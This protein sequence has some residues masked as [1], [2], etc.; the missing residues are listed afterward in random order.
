ML[1]AN[2]MFN[3]LRIS[4]F[5]SIILLVCTLFDKPNKAKNGPD[6]EVSG[7]VG[8]EVNQEVSQEVSQEKS[9]ETSEPINNLNGGENPYTDSYIYSRYPYVEYVPWRHWRRFDSIR[10]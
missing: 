5:A 4:L 3:L 8:E 10:Y 1:N 7:E 2:K 6:E 9:E